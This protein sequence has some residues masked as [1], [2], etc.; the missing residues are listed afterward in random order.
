MKDSQRLEE[1]LIFQTEVMTSSQMTDFYLEFFPY[2]ADM[3]CE[4]SPIKVIHNFEELIDFF[5]EE[6]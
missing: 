4:H 3:K 1:E 5:E 6:N 2:S